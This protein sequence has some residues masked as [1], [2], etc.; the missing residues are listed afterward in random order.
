MVGP[1]W[2]QGSTGT[3]RS[4]L[5]ANDSVSKGK[6]KSQEYRFLEIWFDLSNQ[7]VRNILHSN[8]MRGR[9]PVTGPIPHCCSM[10]EHQNRQLRQRRPGLFQLMMGVV[11]FG[12]ARES[13]MPTGLHDLP[14]GRR[15]LCDGPAMQTSWP[16]PKQA[17]LWRYFILFPSVAK[18]WPALLC[19]WLAGTRCLDRLV[20]FRHEERLARVRVRT[21]G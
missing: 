16:N 5:F 3:A 12:D 13:S 8:G 18:S 1:L 4:R 21:S 19:L 14:W 15:Y 7:T 6:S 2:R 11:G 10:R 9:R 20:R 17:W